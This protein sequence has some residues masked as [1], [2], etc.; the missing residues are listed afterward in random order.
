MMCKS[1]GRSKGH[2]NSG[3]DNKLLHKYSLKICE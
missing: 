1:S 2:G 3:R